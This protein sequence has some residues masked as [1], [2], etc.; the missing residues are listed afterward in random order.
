MSARIPAGALRNVVRGAP[1]RN[2]WG[3]HPAR[4]FSNSARLDVVKPFLLADI[5]EGKIVILTALVYIM[6]QILITSQV[7]ENAK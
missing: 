2:V 4:C 6:N 3:R 5:G 7:S 1:R